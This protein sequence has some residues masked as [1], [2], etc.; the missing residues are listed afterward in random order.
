MIYVLPVTR[1]GRM[2]HTIRDWKGAFRNYNKEGR[3]RPMRA[4]I[5]DYIALV[6]ILMG[7]FSGAYFFLHR[8][9]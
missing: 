1:R 6:S 3:Y 8:R 9:A 7:F 4:N 2:K 5:L